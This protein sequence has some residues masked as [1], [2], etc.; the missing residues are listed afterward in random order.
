MPSDADP[1]PPL[2]AE[3]LAALGVEV[4]PEAGSTNALVADRAREGAPA[5][6]AVATEHQQAGR[7]RLD[8]VW[9]TPPR[10][11]LTFSTLL[12]PNAPAAEW[13]WLP[14]LAGIA[15]VRA[16]GDH[17]VPSGLKWPNDLMLGERK[18]AGILVERVDTPTGPAAV[19]GIGLNV[20]TT[21]AEL[22]VPTATSVLLAAGSA[23]DRTDLLVSLLGHLREQYAAWSSGGGR[24]LRPAYVEACVTLGREVRV[25]LPG[26]GDLTGLATD[27]DAGGRLVVAGTPVAAGDVLHVRPAG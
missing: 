7:G 19:L 27:V 25:A 11:A 1:R 17:G 5:W 23:P 8:R 9:E 15:T 10:A 21:E 3:R 13:P 22:P 2:D 18:A 24:S 26:G 14:L 12:R 4:L 6:L 20:T 16:L